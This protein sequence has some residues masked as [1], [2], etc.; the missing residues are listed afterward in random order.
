MSS[1]TQ[2]FPFIAAEHH[3]HLRACLIFLHILK[4]LSTEPSTFILLYDSGSQINHHTTRHTK[5][6][7]LASRM[8]TSLEVTGNIME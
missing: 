7:R 1:V 5:P 3:H 2:A 6:P 4:P 8:H